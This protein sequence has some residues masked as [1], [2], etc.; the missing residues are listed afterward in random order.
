MAD[1]SLS[2]DRLIYTD[3]PATVIAV[4]GNTLSRGLT[5]E[6]LVSSYF[7]RT[8][9][10]YDSLL[11]MGRWF[12]YRPGYGD[13]PRIWTTED[14]ASDFRFLS[15]IERDLRREI[16]RMESETPLLLSSR[17]GSGSTAGCRSPPPTRCI[18]PSP[19]RPPTAD[20]DH[21][22]PISS[23]GPG[24][25]PH[26]QGGREELISRAIG[27]GAVID[28]RSSRMYPQGP[29]RGVGRGIH[30]SVQIPSGH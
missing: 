14:L 12:G 17:S 8:A 16:T 4:G 24:G 30:P 27:E 3:D 23:T 26:Q 25:D 5:L 15:E 22:L 13:L 18:S 9:Q 19:V 28:P 10:T 21:R 20:N 7:L 1:N 11:Q 29:E 2:T 6:G